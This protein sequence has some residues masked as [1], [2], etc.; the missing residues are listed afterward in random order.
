MDNTVENKILED[1]KALQT[2][3]ERDIEHTNKLGQRLEQLEEQ[4]NER[5]KKIDDIYV[6]IKF[7]INLGKFFTWVGGIILA[8]IA[9]IK[10]VK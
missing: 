10:G 6:G 5:M 9:I 1:I 3:R 8:G 2:H 7:L 4:I